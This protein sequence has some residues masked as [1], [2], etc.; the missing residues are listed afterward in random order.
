MSHSYSS[1]R[2]HLIFSTKNREKWLPEEVQN[3]LWPY[4]AGIA[5]N[6][7]FEA[8]EIGGVEDHA[9]ALVVIP[10][11]MPLAKA[12]QTLKACS[13]KWLNESVT[14]GFSW[15]EGYGAFSVSASQTD[16]VIAYIQNQR[17]HHAKKSFEEEFLSLLKRY[18]ITYD[19]EHVLG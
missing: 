3:K 19:R 2:I 8:I 5:R 17:E 16:G 7:G 11:G 6:H 18:G 15:Q 9:H 10:A 1:N 14:K 13:S 12:I 4:M